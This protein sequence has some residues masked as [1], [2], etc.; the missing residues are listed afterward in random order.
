MKFFGMALAFHNEWDWY[1]YFLD[2]GNHRPGIPI[3]YITFHFY[4][5]SSR[6]DIPGYEV[7]FN[8]ADAFVEEVKNITRIRDAVSPNTKL[9]IDET[10]F[11]NFLK[12]FV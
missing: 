12:F 7:F 4:A 9:D 3:D 2:S 5:S 6:T 11:D 1:Y 10:G 8:Q